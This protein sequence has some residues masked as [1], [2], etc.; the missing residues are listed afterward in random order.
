MCVDPLHIGKSLD[1]VLDNEVVR[2]RRSGYMHK[3]LGSQGDKFKDGDLMNQVLSRMMNPH[4]S[5][6]EGIV[7]DWV[8][9]WPTHS[10]TPPKAREGLICLVTC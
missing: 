4:I 7:D 9:L 8:F 3:F 5:N 1:K 2:N 10:T 6:L